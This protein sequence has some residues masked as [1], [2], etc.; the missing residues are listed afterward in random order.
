MDTVLTGG[1]GRRVVESESRD[2]TLVPELSILQVSQVN[3]AGRDD[4][5]ER[6]RAALMSRIDPAYSPIVWQ[7]HQE[8]SSL[9]TFS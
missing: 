4:L 6:V 1:F 7:L 9:E 8:R 5:K 2:L 3:L